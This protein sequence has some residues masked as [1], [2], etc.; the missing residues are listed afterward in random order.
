MEPYLTVKVDP[1]PS[2]Q[3]IIKRVTL[4]NQAMKPISSNQ[5][6]VVPGFRL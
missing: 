1:E 3:I 4:T 2:L 5:T 6:W